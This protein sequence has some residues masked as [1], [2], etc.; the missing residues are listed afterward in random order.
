M[1]R[2]LILLGTVVAA[3]GCGLISSDVTNFSLD[4]PDKTFTVDASSWQVNSTI[5][6]AYLSYPCAATPSYC[7]SAVTTACASG[8]AGSCDT[9]S[10]TCDLS[11]AVSVYSK[12]DLQMDQPELKTINDQPVIHVSIDSVTY[13]IADN[14]LN[15]ATPAMTIYVA[16]MSVVDPDDPSATA[17]GTIDP[18]PAGMAITTPVPVTF[19]TGGKQ[20]LIDIMSTFKTPF[21]VIVGS[22]LVIQSGDPLPTGKLDADVHITAHAGV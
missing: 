9:T 22:T 19:T 16:P 7:S 3:G 10:Q 11:L 2:L 20:A 12:V 4:L 21:N 8:C 14:S 5:A 17:I 13:A 18:V 15:V 1:T 6:Q